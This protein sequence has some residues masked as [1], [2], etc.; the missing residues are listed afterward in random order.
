MQKKY[1]A[2]MLMYVDWQSRIRVTKVQ[3]GPKF[4]EQNAVNTNSTNNL[5]GAL[6]TPDDLCS[7]DSSK[8]R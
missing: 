2:F 7:P 1:V 8:Y 5:N 3:L 4:S 6:T